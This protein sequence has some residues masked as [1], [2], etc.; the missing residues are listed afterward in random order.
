MSPLY[1]SQIAARA[2]SGDMEARRDFDQQ[3]VP[4]IETVVRRLLKQQFREFTRRS[5]GHRLGRE[6]PAS[7]VSSNAA[8]RATRAVCARLIR[9]FMS[10]TRGVARPHDETLVAPRLLD[11]YVVSE[12]VATS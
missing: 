2:A 9:Q 11:T 7:T 10:P 6:A 12:V 5:D 8:R 1:L 4:L 3:L